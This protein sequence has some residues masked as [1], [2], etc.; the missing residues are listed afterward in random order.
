MRRT[1]AGACGHPLSHL[2]FALGLP[3]LTF[4]R[5]EL[6]LVAECGRALELDASFYH[7]GPDRYFGAF[8]AVA[9]PFAGGDVVKSQ[10]HYEKSLAAAP[11]FLGTKVLMA[12]NLATKLDDIEMFDRLLAEVLAAD[13]SAVPPEI[14]PEMEIEQGKAKELQAL[15]E[16]EDWF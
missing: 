9:P 7:N 3:L 16:S 2:L 4:L 15:K 11:Y 5:C 8:Y 1:V 6:C 14:L 10:E 12:E 13:L